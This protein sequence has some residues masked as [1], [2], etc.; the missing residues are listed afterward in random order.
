MNKQHEQNRAC[1]NSWADWWRERTDQRGIWQKCHR[2]PELVLS[3]SEMHFLNDVRGKDVCVLGSGDN[4][5]VFALAGMGA[6]VTSVDISEKQLE[7]AEERAGILGL[8]VS[9]LRADVIDLSSIPDDSF[10][11]VYT[12]GHMSVWISDITK[13]YAEG[14]RVLRPGGLFI[15]NDYHPIRRMWLESDGPKPLHRYFNRGPYEEKTKEGFTQVEFHWTTA[16]H[17]QAVVDAGC[18]LARVDEHG[19]CE[20]K[21][22]YA[23]FTPS[24]LPMYLMIVGR[25][26]QPNKA[27]AGDF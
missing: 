5:V 13:Y 20:E 24:T 4:E 27:D 23:K 26:E 25:K 1:W 16:D 7:I 2:N 10:D 21:E 3:P 14:V 19:E 8:D 15:V 6:R 18:I 17:I 11:I 12:G 9:F 22:E